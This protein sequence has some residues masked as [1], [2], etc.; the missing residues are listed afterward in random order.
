MH[1]YGFLPGFLVFC[2]PPLSCLHI[3]YLTPTFTLT[4]TVPPGLP[5]PAC[6]WKATAD[7]LGERMHLLVGDVFLSAACISYMGAFTGEGCT[8]LRGGSACTTWGHS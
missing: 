1:L 8:G 7:D 3:L 2:L 4:I 5:L 6:R